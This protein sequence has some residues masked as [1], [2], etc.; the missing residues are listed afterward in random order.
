MRYVFECSGL[1]KN[2]IDSAY[3]ADPGIEVVHG[4]RAFHVVDGEGDEDSEC[5]D[6]LENF[7]LGEGEDGMADAVGGNLEEVF[8]ERNRPTEEDG[9]Q[10]GFGFQVAQMG[11]PRKGHEDV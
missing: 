7:E 3:H 4:E 1:S 8:E 6:F 11:V 5:D 9:D 10:E 2:E